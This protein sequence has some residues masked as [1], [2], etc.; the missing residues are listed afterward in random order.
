MVADRNGKEKLIVFATIHG[1]GS[2]IHVEFLCLNCCLVVDR[3]ILLIDTTAAVALFADVHQLA[4]QAVADIHHSGRADACLTELGY[5]VAASFWL[6]LTLQQVFLAGEVWLEVTHF[7]QVFVEGCQLLV[8][9][10]CF[11][12]AI[13]LRMSSTCP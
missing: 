12:S 5:D 10:L 4:A 7:L 13:F 3:D 9:T 11:A 2:E 1:T 6:E 8:V